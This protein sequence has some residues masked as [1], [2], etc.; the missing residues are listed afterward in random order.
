MS[1]LYNCRLSS[2]ERSTGEL[3]V[4][5]LEDAETQ[6]I[7]HGQMKRFLDEY[8]AFADKKSLPKKS[9]LMKLNPKVDDDGVLRCDGRLKYAEK[10]PYDVRFPVTL[11]RKS[12][13]TRLIVKHYH[14]QDNHVSGTNQ[15]L[16][17]LSTRYWIVSGREEI[18][19]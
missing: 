13:V 12:W 7:K 18:R 10:L 3:T 19:E 16:A 14:E 1:F 4:D 5:E 2:A 6:I 15:T 9:K 11:A 17:S 8:G